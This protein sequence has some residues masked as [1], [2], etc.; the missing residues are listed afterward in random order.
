MLSL[1]VCIRYLRVMYVPSSVSSTGWP[2][3]ERNSFMFFNYG[4]GLYWIVVL[5]CQSVLLS[6]GVKIDRLQTL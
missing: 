3:N 4:L 1:F 6:M 2:R 5:C